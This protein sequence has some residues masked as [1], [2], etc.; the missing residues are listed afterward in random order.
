[1][2]TAGLRAC[3]VVW[4]ALVLL[5]VKTI[6]RPSGMLIVKA[7]SRYPSISR[8]GCGSS[9]ITVVA[10]ISVGFKADVSARRTIVA[11]ALL[12]EFLFGVS[13]EIVIRIGG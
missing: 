3:C 2:S 1:M 9:S 10:A 6:T 11:H 12:Y 7:P 4:T 8:F 5:S 13:A